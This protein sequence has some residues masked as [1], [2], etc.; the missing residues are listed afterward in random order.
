LDNKLRLAALQEDLLLIQCLTLELEVLT[1][2]RTSIRDAI[3]R[4]EGTH[5]AS[6]LGG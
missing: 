2:I 6:A 4:H 3:R 1:E 5:V